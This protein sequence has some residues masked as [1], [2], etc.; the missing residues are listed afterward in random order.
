M[1][2]RAEGP[3]LRAVLAAVSA[4]DTALMRQVVV[5]LAPGDTETEDAVRAWAAVEPRAV[6]LDNPEGIVSPGLNLAIAACTQR[7]VVRVDGHCLVPPELVS[8][9]LETLVRTGAACAGP[10]LRTCGHGQ[11]QRGV[12]AAMSS[13]LGVGGARFRTGGASG[14]VDTVAFGMYERDEL[15]RLGGFRADLV[16]NQDDELNA[17]L[18]RAGGRV[19]LDTSVCVDYVPRDSL[20]GLARQYYEYGY[21]RT[22]TARTCGDPLR[23]RQLVPGVLVAGLAAG[24]VTAAAASWWPL[25]VG[26]ASYALVLLALS[27]QTLRRSRRVRVAAVAPVAAAVMHLAYGTGLWRS[28]LRLSMLRG[29]LPAVPLPR[30]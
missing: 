13:R 21:W 22:V 7:Y 28:A 14:W 3:A 2:V 5:A 30:T 1:P 20:R 29:R 26:A 16:R 4:Q 12:A 18:R 27:G 17:R 6:V 15:R 10:R 19:Y 25:A 23:P 9:L 8:R 24:L 11:V